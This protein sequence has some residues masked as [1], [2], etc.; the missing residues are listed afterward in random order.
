MDIETLQAKAK[1]GD[2]AA[3]Y[4][5]AAIAAQQGNAEQADGWLRAAASS[6]H[7]DALFTLATRYLISS[8]T[9][10]DAVELLEKAAE[11]GGAAA[12]RMLSSL[13]AMGLYEPFSWKIA[14]RSIV[15]LAK[16]G[17]RP[18][19]R[20][21]AGL[22]LLAPDGIATAVPLINASHGADPIAAAVSARLAID[23]VSGL[24]IDQM[25]TSL[26]L[27][28]KAGYPHG[29]ALQGATEVSDS[30]PVST[31]IDWDTIS[32]IATNALQLDLIEQETICEQPNVT[33]AKGVFS[34]ALCEYVVAKS[35]P[36]LM[37]STVVDPCDGQSKDDPYR[38]SL[39]A[40]IGPADHDLTMVAFNHRIAALTG[41]PYNTGEFL[42]VLQY[43]R[44]DEYRPHF[45]W[46]GAGG[47]LDLH[48]QRIRTALIYLN[49]D[50]DGG[51][52][53]FM[54]P[55]LK[56]QGK[57]GDL[58]TFANID[59]EGAV[60]TTSRHAGL[61]IVRGEKWLASKWYRERPYRF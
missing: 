18:A 7:P 32:S 27:L 46:L 38:S 29:E 37:P 52:T 42:S 11:S 3:Q 28:T 10:K 41:A 57:Q 36:L 16:K 5:L 17:D 51:E 9:V 45:D 49:D 1:D 14:V 47:D 59:Q 12:M 43:R 25:K 34:A 23:G 22:C 19:L 40:T 15:V 20:D 13:G 55:D 8:S 24:D 21:L 6:G 44:G 30:S 53:Q 61:P 2:P 26:G 48:G 31:E 50:Y 35:A 4:Q 39:T 33:L 58:L 56:V 54:L 60:D